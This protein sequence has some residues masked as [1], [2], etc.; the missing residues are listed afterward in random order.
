MTKEDKTNTAKS[1]FAKLLEEALH[2][3]NYV[4]LA[5]FDDI[6]AYHSVNTLLKRTDKGIELITGD[7]IQP[8]WIV[9]IDLVYAPG[10]EHIEDFTCDC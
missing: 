7:I 10:Y 1:D 3:R 5:Y 2:I 6:H 8:E 4:K 9:S